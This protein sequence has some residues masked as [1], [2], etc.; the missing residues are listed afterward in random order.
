[1]GLRVAIDLDGT[2]ADL[3]LAMHDIAKKK[4]RK[5]QEPEPDGSVG[6]QTTYR[7]PFRIE[8]R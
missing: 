3:S 1:M 6:G 7:L 2:V 5:L 8:W 4:F